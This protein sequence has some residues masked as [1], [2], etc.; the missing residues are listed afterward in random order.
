M[1]LRTGIPKKARVAGV[2]ADLV[3]CCN[4][5][6]TQQQ[7]SKRMKR[8][9]TARSYYDAL[10]EL[11]YKGIIKRYGTKGSYLYGV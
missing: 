5:P 2:V 3:E 8:W 9:Y 10:N 11:V 7:V 6:V 4:Y 1:K